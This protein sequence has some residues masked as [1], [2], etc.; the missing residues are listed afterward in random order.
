MNLAHA[1]H[2]PGPTA[3]RGIDLPQLGEQAE[4]LD[5]DSE[6]GWRRP[7][8]Q[9]ESA[10]VVSGAERR[11][12]RRREDTAGTAAKQAARPAVTV[13]PAG[14]GVI[15]QTDRHVDTQHGRV[16]RD[17]QDI[18]EAPH[19]M[20]DGLVAGGEDNDPPGPT[21][22]GAGDFCSEWWLHG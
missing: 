6:R 19:D 3:K 7:A 2:E 1:P 22:V 8:I 17:V 20:H 16:G 21:A 13:S 10:A 12:N 11:P 4:A 14:H 5:G 9:R 18:D 15:E